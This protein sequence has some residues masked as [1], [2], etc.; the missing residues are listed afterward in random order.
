MIN[1]ALKPNP[2]GLSVGGLAFWNINSKKSKRKSES[3]EKII[4]VV[5]ISLTQELI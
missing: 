4:E 1:K 2:Y 3:V 5:L